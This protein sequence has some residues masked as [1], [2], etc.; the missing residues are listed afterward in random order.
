MLLEIPPYVGLLYLGL[1]F[2]GL[3]GA[4]LATSIRY[5]ADFVIL[6]VLAGAPR[7]AWYPVAASS[8]LLVAAVWFATLW[9]ISNWRWWVSASLLAIAMLVLGE[10]TLPSDVR[11]Q[12]ETLLQRY[13]GRPPPGQARD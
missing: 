1:H 4:A 7:R 12:I 6:T 8:I 5:A 2:W 9:D 3:P 13:V 10:R 11:L